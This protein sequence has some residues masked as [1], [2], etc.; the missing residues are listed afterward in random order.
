MGGMGWGLLVV[1]TVGA[2]WR[3]ERASGGMIRFGRQIGP[4]RIRAP[5][6]GSFEIRID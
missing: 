1:W 4:I 5:V 3:D 2:G 6:A